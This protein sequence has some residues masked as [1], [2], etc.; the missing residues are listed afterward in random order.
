M[1]HSWIDWLNKHALTEPCPTCAKVKRPR[2]Q[3]DHIVQQVMIC[4]I[5]NKVWI[6]RIDVEL[7]IAKRITHWHYS[8][9]QPFI[10][11]ELE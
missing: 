7:P 8:K 4:P 9:T 2:K 3:G 11:K 10:T 5:C 6:Y 1:S